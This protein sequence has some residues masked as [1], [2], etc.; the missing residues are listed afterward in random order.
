MEKQIA[1]LCFTNINLKISK[2]CQASIRK[3]SLLIDGEGF[4]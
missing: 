2:K 4:L 3:T 1:L